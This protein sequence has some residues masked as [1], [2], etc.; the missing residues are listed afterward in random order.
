MTYT[1]W[2]DATVVISFVIAVVA[3]AV[4]IVWLSL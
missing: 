4:M 1:D 2:V 3:S